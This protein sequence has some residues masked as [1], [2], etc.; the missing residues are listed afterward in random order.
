[1]ARSKMTDSE[2]EARRAV[3][4]YLSALEANKPKRGRK[5]TPESIDAR[6]ASLDEATESASPLKKLEMAQERRD[7]IEERERMVEAVDPKALESA[8][9]SHA[10]QYGEQ[11][12]IS[13]A[14]WRDVGVAA[15]VLKAAGISRSS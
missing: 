12:G 5:R 4:Q 15:D 7:L 2:K 3:R 13:W 8:F 10:Q 1:M 11:K 9:V 6:L 14:A